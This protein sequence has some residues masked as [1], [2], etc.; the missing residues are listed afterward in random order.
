MVSG[1]KA[2]E[3]D[4][5]LNP[6]RPANAGPCNTWPLMVSSL[7]KAFV[8]SSF[9]AAN[10][11]TAAFDEVAVQLLKRSV[12]YD[13]V[14]LKFVNAT[15]ESKFPGTE[16][17]VP[18][19]ITVE[20]MLT[21]RHSLTTVAN[22]TE[23]LNGGVPLSVAQIVIRFVVLPWA[24]SG[25]QEKYP[26]V[27]LIEAPAGAFWSVNVKLLLPLKSLATLVKTTPLP[28]IT[29]LSGIGGKIGA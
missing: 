24:Q 9:W 13:R 1:T 16:L 2:D 7:K 20:P 3:L 17:V 5:A 22:V 11:A 28:T 14:K 4:V 27:G 23:L 15:V 29:D 12:E 25:F 6:T 21:C 18:I 8:G 19:C 10:L 26:F